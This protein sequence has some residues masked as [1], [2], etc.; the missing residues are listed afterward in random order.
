MLTLIQDSL[1]WLILRSLNHNIKVVP[2]YIFTSNN[3]FRI[4]IYSHTF[5]KYRSPT[6]SIYNSILL[7]P[8]LLKIFPSCP[9]P[10]K[11]IGVA[12]S[13]LLLVSDSLISPIIIQ[14]SLALN[15][16]TSNLL[17]WITLA[18]HLPILLYYLLLSRVLNST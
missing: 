14:Q 4:T 8:I 18:Y 10:S 16:S 15:L 11:S 13:F 2:I 5:F 12:K 3:I 1:L 7:F 6:L 17:T 9:L